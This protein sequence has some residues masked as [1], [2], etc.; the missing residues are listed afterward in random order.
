VEL[1][2][3]FASIPRLAL[4]FPHPPPIE[5]L[6]RLTQ[7][8]HASN[9]DVKLYVKREDCNSGLAGGGNKVRKLEY[10]MADVVANK[11]DTVVTEGGIQ[12][13]HMRQTAAA[14]GKL[15]LKVSHCHIFL[16]CLLSFFLLTKDGRSFP[17]NV[18]LRTH[19]PSLSDGY[20]RRA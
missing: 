18:S 1:P 14:A 2:E 13:N 15:G 3:P 16:S 10:V 9:S 11:A 20:L 6:E 19:F 7:H 5:A 4:T 12:S 8:L 17:R